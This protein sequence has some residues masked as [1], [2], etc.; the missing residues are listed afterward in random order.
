MGD[1]KLSYLK[2][3][4]YCEQIKEILKAN[5]RYEEKKYYQ[6]ESDN[7]YK[8]R[9][10]SE[11]PSKLFLSNGDCLPIR[12]PKSS[13]PHLLGIDTEY[14]INNGFVKATNAYDALI[15]IIEYPDR[16]KNKH[17]DDYSKVASPYIENKLR[18]FVD[19][20][21]MDVHNCEFICKF[22][23]NR[24]YGYNNNN[25]MDYFIVSKV[26]TEDDSYRYDVLILKEVLNAYDK[27]SDDIVYIPQSNQSF[28]SKEELIEEFSDKVFNQELTLLI[29]KL[30][31][32]RKYDP[33]KKQCLQNRPEK[34]K[35]LEEWCSQFDCIPNVLYDY[36]YALKLLN[37]EKDKNVITN[38]YIDS[39]IDD[40][41]K[42]RFVKIKYNALSQE[43]VEFLEAYNDSLGLNGN[44]ENNETFTKLLKRKNDLEK[45]LNE[46][47][48]KKERADVELLEVSQKYED[49]VKENEMLKAKLK[50]ISEAL[51]S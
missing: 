42:S 28:D 17:I 1:Q 39:I 7:E 23:V 30:F 38:T 4:E 9:D 22:D 50:K 12:I 40:I 10:L 2:F 33:N 25:D 32:T 49:V 47:S 3:S 13:V 8:K 14:L 35:T 44:K 45:L 37:K 43:L 31:K 51:N 11:L 15:E 46:V 20:I 41:K 48:E 27:H 29:T 18:A 34:L 24:S 5:F 26:K 21:L 16:L 19:N 36:L 6:E